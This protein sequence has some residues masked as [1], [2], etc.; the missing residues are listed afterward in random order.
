MDKAHGRHSLR[1][2]L[3]RYSVFE[4]M[5]SRHP[6]LRNQGNDSENQ[7]AADG[8]G[9]IDTECRD[10]RTATTTGETNDTSK[11]HHEIVYA[12]SYVFID[13]NK[14]RHSPAWD[15]RAESGQSRS[16]N[17]ADRVSRE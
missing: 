5:L 13:S 17:D 3:L 11:R 4:I 15:G 2:R 8:N 7:T 16:G 1:I 14:W 12:R 6:P 10:G 9:A